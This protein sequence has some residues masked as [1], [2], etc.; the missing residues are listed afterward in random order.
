LAGLAE[1]GCGEPESYA[2]VSWP[3]L[4]KDGKHAGSQGCDPG[5]LTGLVSTG[6]GDDES[7]SAP[8]SEEAPGFA[9][10]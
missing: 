5:L 10:K 7:K 1:E 4:R 6:C 9:Q 2:E 3:D 8:V